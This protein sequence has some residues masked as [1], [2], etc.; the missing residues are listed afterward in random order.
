MYMNIFY[1]SGYVG[2]A[3]LV[4][5]GLY[6]TV[7]SF[8]RHDRLGHMAILLLSVWFLTGIGESAN[9]SHSV[10]YSKFGLGVAIA[11]CSKKR[12][13][14]DAWTSGFRPTAFLPEPFPQGRFV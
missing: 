10:G 11:F 14:V 13:M 12:F 5:F 4:L 6:V 7:C 1:Q 2:L 3:L 8:R 9:I